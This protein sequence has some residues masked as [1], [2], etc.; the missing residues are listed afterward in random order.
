MLTNPSP[1]RRKPLLWSGRVAAALLVTG[2]VV[3]LVGCR[4]TGPTPFL[5][6]RGDNLISVSGL[7]R[8]D[9]WGA[10]PRG[11]QA[12]RIAVASGNS[13]VAVSGNRAGGPGYDSI[14]IFEN[15][16]LLRVIGTAEREA[17]GPSWS[18]RADRLA[19]M[20]GKELVVEKAKGGAKVVLA[21]AEPDLADAPVWSPKGDKLLWATTELRRGFPNYLHYWSID[22]KTGRRQEVAG[23]L[24]DKQSFSSKE[25]DV[26]WDPW[27]PDGRSLAFI[28]RGPLPVMGQPPS[29][30]LRIYELK[31]KKQR[32]VA[33]INGGTWKSLFPGS[34]S[35]DGGSFTY[36]SNLVNPIDRNTEIYIYELK[37]RKTETLTH[38]NLVESGG[39]WSPDGRFIIYNAN[40][41]GGAPGLY[42][43]TVADKAAKRLG[44]EAPISPDAWLR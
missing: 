43:V 11:F 19:Y 4:A 36:S 20:I 25:G 32:V 17:W 6:A 7:G 10:L 26:M 9:K 15:R 37:S 27:S 41:E 14:L 24:A 1:R 23:N 31:T 38:D 34:W 21:T 22:V 29:V 35:P 13:F 8:S 42:I 39:Y 33:A 12:A 5:I 30:A 44:A 2:M 40:G 3:A 28:T 16:R 18:P